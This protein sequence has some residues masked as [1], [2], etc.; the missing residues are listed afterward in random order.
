MCVLLFEK[1]SPNP[2]PRSCGER[3]AGALTNNRSGK[4]NSNRRPGEGDFAT[5]F[6]KKRFNSI[7]VTGLRHCMPYR[8][9]RRIVTSK[10]T[11][12]TTSGKPTA[13]P[14][15]HSARSRSDIATR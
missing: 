11:Q 3:V 12:A 14:Y 15:C 1:A 2:S 13:V 7:S 6:Y 5:R 8:I 4:S 10:P 9:R